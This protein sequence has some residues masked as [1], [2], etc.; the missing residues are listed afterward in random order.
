MAESNEKPLHNNNNISDIF[1]KKAEV[2][3]VIQFNLLQQLIE[4]FIKR[5]QSM[6]DKINNLDKKIS[7]VAMKAIHP[8]QITNNIFNSPQNLDNIDNQNVNL[9][10]IHNKEIPFNDLSFNDNININDEFDQ[11]FNFHDLN[12]NDDILESDNNDINDNNENNDNTENN[13]NN[14]NNESNENNEN[15]DNEN[16]DN[17]NNENY[18]SNDNNDINSQKENKESTSENN[19]TKEEKRSKKTDTKNINQNIPKTTKNF[20]KITKNTGNKQTSK[21]NTKINN[22]KK[23]NKNISNNNNPINKTDNIISTTNL[24]TIKTT[25]ENNKNFLLLSPSKDPS[26]SRLEKLEIFIR[27]FSKK[28]QKIIID[29]DKTIDYL[30]KKIL[31][32]EDNSKIVNDLQSKVQAINATLNDINVYE[33]FKTENT[34][35]SNQQNTEA[36]EENS[37]IL[38]VLSRNFKSLEKHNKLT[39]EEL[40]KLRQKFLEH[41][42]DARNIPKS[43]ENTENNFN[44]KINEVEEKFNSKLEDTLKL[45][46]DNKKDL[47]NLRN[48]VIDLE[49][50]TKKKK[51]GVTIVQPPSPKVNNE[52]LNNLI[53]DSRNYINSSLADTEKYIK[54]LINRLNVEK[55]K[56]DLD[57]LTE[58][59]NSKLVTNDFNKL[60]NY[61]SELEKKINEN[62]TKIENYK[63]DISLCNDTCTK[64]VNMIEYLSG[65]VIQSYQPDVERIQKEEIIKKNTGVDLSM[66][67]GKKLFYEELTKVRNKIEKTLEIENEN[68]KFM[69]HLE[70]RLKYFATENDLRNMEQCFQNLLDELKDENSKKYME[71]SEA[72][73]TFKYLEIQVKHIIENIPVS[74][75][76][77][78]NWLLAK[79]PINSYICA[80]CE[81]YLGDALKEKNIFLPWNKIPNREEKKYRMGN[82][83]S[84]M[85][86]LVNFD[87]MKSA[88]KLN[89]NLS[90]K[91]DDKKMPLPRIGSQLSVKNLNNPNSTFSLLKNNEV[92]EQKLNNSADGN[93]DL[94]NHFSGNSSQ[95]RENYKSK[96]DSKESDSPK[97]VK[98]VKK[99]VK[100]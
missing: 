81:S 8:N 54:S 6:N 14:E 92:N 77:K 43:I 76:E 3:A 15:N 91:V 79:K 20:E 80:S 18:E 17:E 47:S 56:K 32:K 61:V 41:T 31:I 95:E 25:D 24:N 74:S 68:Y 100:K 60:N 48:A 46:N 2:G 63:K 97:V 57:D 1:D 72:T 99:S 84:K 30:K 35:N 82:G 94:G 50:S 96:N 85:L 73:K 29:Q 66:Y 93:E 37:N 71:K 26:L 67:V 23:Q 21:P 45:I 53:L 44:N 16:N 88:E 98:I 13:E 78:D 89:S 59:V 4:E 19:N 10:E 70:D 65:Q 7:Y 38:K 34:S 87:L 9:D 69:Q 36:I 90:I 64:T 49:E 86:Q 58:K 5:Y 33:L 28:V 22:Q 83:F 40:L 11:H 27:N 55:I 52:K 75:K 39:E 51:S 42:A 12:N 62:N